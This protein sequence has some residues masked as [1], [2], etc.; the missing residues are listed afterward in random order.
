MTLAKQTGSRVFYI[1]LYKEIIEVLDAAGTEF[2]GA[3]M[4]C[5]I[6]FGPW[7][8][9]LCRECSFAPP[10][11]KPTQLE[12]VTKGETDCED[13]LFHIFCS[14]AHLIPSQATSYIHVW[15]FFIW[16][17]SVYSFPHTLQGQCRIWNVADGNAAGRLF[18]F[19]WWP[20]HKVGDGNP[21]G[22]LKIVVLVYLMTSY[23]QYV[24]KVKKL[25]LHV[26]YVHRI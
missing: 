26:V 21:A 9:H 16:V 2:N 6:S 14:A 17:V 1:Y 5:G 20:E 13:T 15:L 24:H 4:M 3:F 7:C 25:K 8:C 23:I 22:S 11:P 19:L 10:R 18:Q 12:T